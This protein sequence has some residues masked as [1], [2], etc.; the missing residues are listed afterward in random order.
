MTR[1]NAEGLRVAAFVPRLLMPLPLADLE[2]FIAA[3]DE[4]V[5]MELSYSKQFYNYLRTQVDL[6]KN[7]THV[8]ARSGGSA[9]RVSEVI[10]QVAVIDSWQCAV[11]SR[12]GA[13]VRQ[14]ADGQLPTANCRLPEVTA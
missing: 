13:P 3:C 12:T 5:V 2:A 7:R 4:L 10:E 1:L 6:P 14:T 11:G 8:Y 9:L